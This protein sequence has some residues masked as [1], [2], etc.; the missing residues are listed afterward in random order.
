MPHIWM[1]GYTIT[2]TGWT[3]WTGW[4]EGDDEVEMETFS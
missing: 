1:A 4:D 3:G 2:L